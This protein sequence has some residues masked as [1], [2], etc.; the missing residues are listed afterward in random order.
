[1]G[2]SKTGSDWGAAL[3]MSASGVG[4][5]TTSAAGSPSPTSKSTVKKAMIT[6]MKEGRNLSQA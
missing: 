1:M 6:R 5:M 4:P 2:S 3:A